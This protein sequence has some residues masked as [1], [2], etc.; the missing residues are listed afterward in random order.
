EA[1]RFTVRR[2]WPVPVAAAVAT[3]LLLGQGVVA[4]VHNDKVLS[5]PDTRNVMRAWMVAH[6]PP[7]AKVVIEPLVPN[8][9]ASDI[10]RSLPY[11]QYGQRWSQW[12]TWLSNIGHCDQ[13]CPYWL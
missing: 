10:G 7:G 5:R 13:R 9:W 2:G 1:L 8:T 11:N 3:V 6:V 12:P 4:A